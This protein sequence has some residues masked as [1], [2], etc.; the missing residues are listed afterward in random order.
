MVVLLQLLAHLMDDQGVDHSNKHCIFIAVG[1]EFVQL[2]FMWCSS[3]GGVCQ[4]HKVI[5]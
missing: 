3:H 1:G 2:L 4:S 5:S